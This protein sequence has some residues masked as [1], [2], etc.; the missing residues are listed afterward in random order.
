MIKFL[1]NAQISTMKRYPQYPQL[2]GENGEVLE[3]REG[4]KGPKTMVMLLLYSTK[5]V[6][7]TPNGNIF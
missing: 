3:V 1:C 5:K 6:I 4:K 2:D 7:E